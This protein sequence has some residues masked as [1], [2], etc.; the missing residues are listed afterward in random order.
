MRTGER[1]AAARLEEHIAPDATMDTSTQ[2]GQPVG[3][4]LLEGR[5]AVLDR[6]HGLWPAT[7]GYKRAGWSSPQPDGDKLVVKGT[8]NVTLTFS[9]NDADQI[10]HVQ[11]DGG[12]GGFSYQEIDAI[13]DAAKA[14]LN[15]ALADDMPIVV[16]YVDESGQPQSSLRGSVSV[17][18]DTQI[19]IWIRH[20]DGGLPTAIQK[21]PKV[22]LVYSD[23]R[24]RQ[25]ILIQGRAHIETDEETR[26]RVFESAPEV[27]Q[28][29]DP[30]RHGEALIID[31]TRY[32]GGPNPPGGRGTPRMIREA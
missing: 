26:R 5:A 9:F 28:L 15:N 32:Q 29:H 14:L 3:R 16:T 31:V 23:R 10:K 27:E 22:S 21:N 25:L 30:H 1:T 12:W 17:F 6:V 11:L 20:G 4:E 19:A 13:P 7:P 2:P 18:S 24:A 8:N